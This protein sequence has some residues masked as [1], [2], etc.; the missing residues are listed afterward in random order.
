MIR[1]QLP[2]ESPI[3]SSGATAGNSET[4]LLLKLGIKPGW[5]LLVISPPA[6][7]WELL[8]SLPVGVQVLA[9]KSANYAHEP[10]AVYEQVEFIHI[11]TSSFAEL[12]RTLQTYQRRIVPHGMIWVSWPKK[13]SGIRSDLDENRIRELA[14]Q[15]K[16]VDVKVAA[17]D[18]TW[19]GLKL[20][21]RRMD[22]PSG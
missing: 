15:R 9:D 19:S 16:L 2:T 11:F 13:S 18:S 22:R 7:Y 6:D 3:D 12:E 17:I 14:L 10:A 21:I 5:R 1:L 4:P 20:V 8:G